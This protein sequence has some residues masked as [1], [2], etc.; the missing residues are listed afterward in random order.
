MRIGRR[1]TS[2]LAIMASNGSNI[3]L[4]CGEAT[5]HQ[6]MRSRSVTMGQIDLILITHLHG[7]HCYGS[8]T[9]TF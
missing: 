7:D 8:V 9:D 5:Q 4:D 3:L 1:N 6:I 2:G